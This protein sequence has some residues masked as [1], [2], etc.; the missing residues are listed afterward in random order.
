MCYTNV[1]QFEANYTTVGLHVF[2]VFGQHKVN[3]KREVM[4]W[5]WTEITRFLNCMYI[6][7]LR[8]IQQGEKTLNPY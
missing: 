7:L 4:R 1:K 6:R 5:N 2:C 3:I 8:F